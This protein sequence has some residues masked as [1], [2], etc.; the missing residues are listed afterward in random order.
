MLTI[1]PSI[2][3]LLADLRMALDPAA[4]FRAAVGAPD[5][6]QTAMLRLPA[7]QLILNCSRQSGKS[8][9]TAVLALHSALYHPGALI[10]IL[11]PSQRQA[12]ELYRKVKG[13]AA[14]M[15]VPSQAVERQTGL[16][17]ELAG[18][19]RIVALPGKEQT[20]RGFSAVSLLIVDEAAR[21]PDDL[22]H[23]IRPMLAVSQGRIA[24]LS[25][26]FGQRGF[27]YEA[28][29]SSA[30]WQRFEVPASACPR[31]DPAFL[32]AERQALGDWWYRQEYECRFSDTNDQIFS[33]LDIQAAV[34]PDLAPAFW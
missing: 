18:G 14:A 28:W 16:T 5:D 23:A 3:P 25:T 9:T 30:D 10:L 19:A 12:V 11:A 17:L 15:G 33:T 4:L 6:W 13:F 27:F 22:Y 31:I 2:R 21:V 8:T 1:S 26:P 24:L 20:I 32:A 34:A 29:R 7:R